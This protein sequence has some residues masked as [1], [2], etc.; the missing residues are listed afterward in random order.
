MVYA[1]L[2]IA[3]LL[4]A[5]V[6][7]VMRWNQRRQV[8]LAYATP[9]PG[10]N[11]NARQ[12]P[13][14]D[15]ESLGIPALPKRTAA[16][17]LGA[18]VD[19]VACDAGMAESGEFLHVHSHL[20]LFVHGRQLQIPAKIGFTPT[21][22]GGCL[23]WIHTHD[24]SGIIHVESPR[25]TAP[26]GDAFTLGS[27]FRVWGEQLTR[28]EIGPYSGKV[29]AFV[30]GAPYAANLDTIPLYSNQQI[31]L[32]IGLPIVKPPRYGFPPNY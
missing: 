12:I 2:A 20:A 8:S 31:T 1:T 10:A 30:N 7:G 17:P 22:T 4:I 27:F 11:A 26:G 32:E 16:S 6:F 3:V 23:Y 21:A 19:G 18:P 28:R 13:L 5:L 9:S 29:T 24:A 15:G 14:T 25:L